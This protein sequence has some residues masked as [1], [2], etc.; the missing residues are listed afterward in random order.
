MPPLPAELPPRP[1]IG[2]FEE[3]AINS[4]Q[5]MQEQEREEEEKEEEKEGEVFR[6]FSFLSSSSLASWKCEKRLN[7]GESTEWLSH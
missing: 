3:D 2:F 1:F 7:N 6:V 4:K 5:K